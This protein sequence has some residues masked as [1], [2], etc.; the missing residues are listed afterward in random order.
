MFSS[1]IKPDNFIINLN[2]PAYYA[3]ETVTGTV[4]L[5]TSKDIKC[6]CVKF[7]ICGEG[8]SFFWYKKGK[9]DWER[10]TRRVTYFRETHTLWGRFFRTEE[11]PT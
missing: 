10:A 8:F 1:K 7:R 6:R 9:D 2:K 4:T 3:G 11:V 5:K